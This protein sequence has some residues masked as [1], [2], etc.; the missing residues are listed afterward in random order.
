VGFKLDESYNTVAERIA[1]FRAKH[2]DGSLQPADL[3]KPF[4]IE[5]VN[6]N[7]CFVVT[8]AAYRAPDDQRPGIGMAYEPVP[9]ATQFTRGSELQN[10]ETA[11][12]GRAIVAALAADTNKG[13]A[14]RDEIQ[15]RQPEQQQAEDRWVVALRQAGADRTKL[16]A[17][18][19]TAKSAG[20]PEDFWLFQTIEK[21][22]ASLPV[23]GSE[24]L[25]GKL[26]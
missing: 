4:T 11:A 16:E 7:Q 14:S 15:A 12:W 24:P 23:G 19:H 6:G 10:A 22:L 8:A 21:Q 3:T 13:V 1:E 25:E 9:G 5:T 2:P 20:A 18:R 26:V 17:L